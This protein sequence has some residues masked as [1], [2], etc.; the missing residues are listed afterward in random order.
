MSDL[1]G[2]EKPAPWSPQERPNDLEDYRGRPLRP[3]ELME[4]F[5]KMIESNGGGTNVGPVNGRSGR[6][7]KRVRDRHKLAVM[8]QVC[9]LTNNEIAANLG[10]TASRVSIILNS[11]KE[12]LQQVRRDTVERVAERTVDLSTKIRLKAPEAFDKMVDLLESD[13]ERIVLE[14]AKDI[15]DRAGYAPVKKQI[16]AHVPVPMSELESTLDKINEANE[17]AMKHGDWE[18]RT[19]PVTERSA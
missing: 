9:G 4:R 2:P 5:K 6:H 14:S 15:L 8:L 16:N 13:N 17:V 12:E 11:Q 7:I 1:P 19:F 3:Q 10:Y 18:V